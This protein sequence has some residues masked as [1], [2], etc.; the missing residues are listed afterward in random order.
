MR[1]LAFAAMAEESAERSRELPGQPA[2]ARPDTEPEHDPEEGHSPEDDVDD[3]GLEDP[4]G[5]GYED[6]DEYDDG[7]DGQ[8][9]LSRAGHFTRLAFH[10]VTLSYGTIAA[11]A[12]FSVLVVLAGPIAAAIGAF[13]VFAAAYVIVFIVAGRRA[14]ADFYEDYADE[15][16]LSRLVDGSLPE[17]TPLLRR[18]DRR[19]AE[20]VMSGLLP[21]GLDGTLAL[22][23]YEREAQE[24]DEDA[25]FDHTVVV[26]TLSG[27]P[28]RLGALYCERKLGLSGASGEAAAPGTRTLQLGNWAFDA[29]YQLM[30]G[31][32]SDDAT[33]RR[34]L[35]PD[36]VSWLVGEAPPEI[37][38]ELVAKCLTV[39]IEGHL[40]T[41]EE[42]DEL[43]EAAAVIA[44]TL[45]GEPAPVK[46]ATGSVNGEPESTAEL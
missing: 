42:L 46:D 41:F 9:D 13:V 10:P 25:Y 32:G 35:N 21:G 16:G 33:V 39:S 19:G 3:H 6:E 43:C 31:G 5:N 38:F 18:G 15:H 7:A 26:T 29:R 23:T 20:Q 28:L 44:A 37:A 2:Q 24:S 11:F 14:S 22:Y 12:V 17:A 8:D 1:V 4:D 30:R 40:D 45:L 36:F 27:S 34:L